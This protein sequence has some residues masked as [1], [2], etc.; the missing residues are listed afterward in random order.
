MRWL[1]WSQPVFLFPDASRVPERR[2]RHRKRAG[3]TVRGTRSSRIACVT[4]NPGD[5]VMGGLAPGLGPV[6]GSPGPLRGH[7]TA[8]RLVGE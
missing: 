6:G 7:A 2:M 1:R 5:S 8:L 4:A 3:T